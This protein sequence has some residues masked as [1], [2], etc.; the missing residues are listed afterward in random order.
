MLGPVK[1]QFTLNSNSGGNFTARIGDIHNYTFE[2]VQFHLPPQPPLLNFHIAQDR[3]TCFVFD[4][5][6]TADYLAIILVSH[7]GN[8]LFVRNTNIEKKTQNLFPCSYSK[9]FQMKKSSMQVEELPIEPRSTQFLV[10]HIYLVITLH[11]FIDEERGS[12]C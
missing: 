4:K 11:P 6:D 12:V 3:I 7:S 2:E 8:I 9:N 10:I 1:N 5:K